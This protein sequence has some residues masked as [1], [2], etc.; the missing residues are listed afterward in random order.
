MASGSFWR[1]AGT[2]LQQGLGFGLKV[3]SFAQDQELLE[4]RKKTLK[5]QERMQW[6]SNLTKASEIED[7]GLR[8]FAL[9]TIGKE[10]RSDDGLP[11]LSDEVLKGIKQ[12]GDSQRRILLGLAAKHGGSLLEGMSDDEITST[13]RKPADFLTFLD[14]M[15]TAEQSSAKRQAQ[16]AEQEVYAQLDLSGPANQQLANVDDGHS[17]RAGAWRRYGPGDYAAQFHP[18]PDEPGGPGALSAAASR[19]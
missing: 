6:F 11:V 16:V 10:W 18:E 5:S 19:V 8:N 15:N 1:G 3:A 17:A 12:T 2:G 9:D 14:K 4:Q 13:F 7:T